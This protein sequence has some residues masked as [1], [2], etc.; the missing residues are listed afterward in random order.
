MGET[1]FGLSAVVGTGSLYARHDHTH[2]SPNI[3][4]ANKGDLLT[5]D[6]SVIKTLGSGTSG[7]F[8]MSDST[9]AYG[10]SWQTTASYTP[11]TTVMG[12]VTY[13]LSPVVGTGSFYARHDHT[14]GSP[15]IVIANRGSLLSHDG[16]SLLA[17]ASGTEGQVL[18]ID[19]ITATGLS[20]K[21]TG[22]YTAAYTVKSETSFGIASSVGTGS[23]YAREDHTHG[24]PSIVIANKGD[25]L[26][27]D[28]AALKVQ[29]SGTD[30]QVLAINPA[31]TTGLNWVST[32]SVPIAAYSVKSET[33]F[34][35]GSSVGTGSLYAREDHTH[36]TPSIE[37]AN[38]GDLLSHDGSVLKAVGSGS[39]DQVLTVDST[40]TCGLSW[41][42]V[43]KQHIYTP[44]ALTQVDRYVW[45]YL[46]EAQYGTTI[47]KETRAMYL[48]VL[49][50]NY[51]TASIHFKMDSVA[52]G[53]GTWAEIAILEGIPSICVGAD[54][55]TLGYV[56]IL[57]EFGSASFSHCVTVTGTFSVGTEAW[58]AYGCQANVQPTFYAAFAEETECGLILT[59]SDTQPSTMT[60]D[61]KFYVMVPGEA[62]SDRSLWCHVDFT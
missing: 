37:I 51:T 19:S 61:T 41:K 1:T 11:A 10:L 57:T 27:H 17:V 38:K 9:A 32:G 54:L 44:Y 58:V 47:N 31:S 60:A 62:L 4:L 26:S 25:L 43:G 24:T 20:W 18:T 30:G 56:N 42:T 35:I 28:G 46:T 53:G 7:K 40:A 39:N 29:A 34:G 52:I 23:L 5:H 8:L 2:G 3:L 45:A 21:T 59:A 22:S 49:E 15:S 33:S 16:S 6:G 14:H 50:N 36:G 12:E 13:G 48:G 55:T